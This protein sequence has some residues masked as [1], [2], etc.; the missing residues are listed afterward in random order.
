MSLSLS[1]PRRPLRLR[2]IEPDPQPAASPRPM[3]RT[4]TALG[5]YAFV[6]AASLALLVRILKLW[7][8]DLSVP[9]N[10]YRDALLA[11]MWTKG[12]LEHG[13]YLRNPSLGAPGELQ[14]HDYP[15]AEGLHFCMLK[16]LGLAT[17][18]FGVA[19][20]LYYLLGFPL[21]AITCLFALR[22][23]QVTYPSAMAASLWLEKR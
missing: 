22:R 16:L 23:F 12:V 21:A 5:A 11:Q 6:A 7:L 2:Q 14:M 10:D 18:D 20:N 13:W 15:L 9:M 4:L 17:P 8:A 19:F 1:S 3:R